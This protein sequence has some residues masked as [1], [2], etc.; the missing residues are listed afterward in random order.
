METSHPLCLDHQPPTLHHRTALH[1]YLDPQLLHL[2]ALHQPA[3][4]HSYLE[5][6]PH[7]L[8]PL[9]RPSAHHLYLDL[10]THRQQ[11][12]S[13]HS[14]R[15]FPQPLQVLHLHLNLCLVIMSALRHLDLVQL[16]P[17]PEIMIR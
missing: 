5:P 16:L 10:R 11:L 4:L 8:R 7:H 3:A 17:L 13:S 14:H 6:A 12:P 15:L 9:H 2:P 1:L